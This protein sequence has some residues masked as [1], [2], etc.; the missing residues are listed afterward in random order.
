MEKL[1]FENSLCGILT[2]FSVP[3]ILSDPDGDRRA[4]REVAWELN[5][6]GYFVLTALEQNDNVKIQIEI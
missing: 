5:P 3:R 4:L 6:G 1:S 2:A